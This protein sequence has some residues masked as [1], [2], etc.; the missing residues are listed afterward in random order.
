MLHVLSK[1]Y[2]FDAHNIHE[3]ML[4]SDGKGPVHNLVSPFPGSEVGIHTYNTGH[5]RWHHALVA[6]AMTDPDS[7][8]LWHNQ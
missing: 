1:W 5:V 2:E 4:K 3:H 6:W 8:Q 7:S